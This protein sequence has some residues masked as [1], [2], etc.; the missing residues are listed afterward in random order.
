MPAWRRAMERAL[1]FVFPFGIH[2]RL[3]WRQFVAYGLRMFWWEFV[4]AALGIILLA[5]RVLSKR[6]RGSSPSCQLPAASCF[7][8]YLLVALVVT[9]WLVLMYGSWT[10]TDNP[11]PTQITVGNSHVRYWLPIFVAWVPLAAVAL[12]ELAARAKRLG[13]VVLV[14]GWVAW[15]A[16]GFRT[17][18]L[19]PED[20]LFAEAQVL[21]QERAVH[22]AVM[23][24]T[25]ADAVIVVDRDDKIFFPDRAVRYPLRDPRTYALLPA[26]VA[27]APTYYFGITLPAQDL[28]Y[29]NT[30]KLKADGLTFVPVQTFGIETLY[31]IASH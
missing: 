5:V 3:A 18:F 9:V 26:L 15:A 24:L 23:R 1:S 13:S 22:D 16:L 31:V 14:V 19:T 4:L 27:H 17:A 7:W 10:F 29:L 6:R 11:D 30:D 28:N 8:P 20:G 2:P 25:P 21:A 12:D